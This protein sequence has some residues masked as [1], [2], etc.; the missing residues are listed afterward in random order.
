MGRRDRHERLRSPLRRGVGARARRSRRPLH[1]RLVDVRVRRRE[2]SRARRI[3]A[4]RHARRSGVRRH[5]GAL[6][7]AQG[8]LRGRGPRGVRPPR[9]RRAPR[10]HRRTVRPDRPLR[11]LGRAIRLPRGRSARAASAAVV[12]APPERAVQ[13]IDA[14]D[15]A[16]W[17]LDMAE[18]RADGTFDACSPAG[19][20]TMGALVDALVG[21]GARGRQRGR[22]RAWI[23]DAM[24]V[25]PRR[26]AVDRAA[27]V[28]S[29]ERPGVRRVHGVRAARA[30]S[31]TASLPAARR[32]DRRHRGVAA[33]ARHAA[34]WRNVLSAEKER[35]LAMSD[36]AMPRGT[37]DDW[38]IV[39]PPAFA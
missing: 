21:G 14:R 23:D 38:P 12:P 36:A 37:C 7:R 32:D 34:A 28:D 29:R 4:G 2:P 5:H 6:R 9:A 22:C 39:G 31:R 15:L 18:Q 13:F 35:A 8:A 19:T 1:V 17:M 3:H 30:R 25:A 11:L 27:A 16:S 26:H 10:A 33:R 20:W 24:L